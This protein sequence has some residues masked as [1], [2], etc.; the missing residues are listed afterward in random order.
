MRATMHP[1]NTAATPPAYAGN[2]R[3]K[4]K[5]ERAPL[6]AELLLEAQWQPSDATPTEGEGWFRAN[7]HGTDRR[8]EG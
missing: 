3:R 8:R 4:G 6:F 2:D 5:P 1:T 7:G